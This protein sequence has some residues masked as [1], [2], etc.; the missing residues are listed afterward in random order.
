MQCVAGLLV[1]SL[2]ACSFGLVG[3]HEPVTASETCDPSSVDPTLDT[4][5]AVGFLALA[6]T[7]VYEV[8]RCKSARRQ[9]ERTHP[10]AEDLPD[11]R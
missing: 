2:A 5:G 4:V 3:P 11:P 1:V 6:G 10:P 9:L 8:G 7:A